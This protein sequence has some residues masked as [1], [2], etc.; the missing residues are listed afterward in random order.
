MDFY[1]WED[2]I[3]ESYK[4]VKMY[5]DNNWVFK[6]YEGEYF[7]GDEKEVRLIRMVIFVG[8][9]EFVKWFCRVFLLSG[10]FCFRYDRV[11]CFFYGKIILRDEIGS[12]VI[13]DNIIFD[14]VFEILER[15]SISVNVE[16]DKG[17]F[18]VDWKEI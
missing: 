1:F 2:L 4:V 6:E 3:V 7:V 18:V 11:K 14:V 12:F 17:S 9:F 13:Y 5:F 8:S 15:K 10:K 16:E